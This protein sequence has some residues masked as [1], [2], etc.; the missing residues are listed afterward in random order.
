VIEETEM[1]FKVEKPDFTKK[2]QDPKEFE[3][4]AAVEDDDEKE[5]GSESQPLESLSTEVALDPAKVGFSGK[6]VQS[7]MAKY[8]VVPDVS[9]PDEIKFF[10]IA[11]IP[12]EAL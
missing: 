12:R 8:D 10:F 5:E 7:V 4:F 1:F 9:K 2:I 11:D 3:A 6:V